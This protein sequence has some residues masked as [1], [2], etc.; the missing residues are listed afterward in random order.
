MDGWRSVPVAVR[1]K[2]SVSV[3]VKSRCRLEVGRYHHMADIDTIL[4]I[5]ISDPKYWRCSYHLLQ[6]S[7]AY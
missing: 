1:K 4:I 6:H 5:D 7:L 2:Y 3:T